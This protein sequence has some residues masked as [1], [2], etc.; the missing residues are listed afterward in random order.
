MHSND[1]SYPFCFSNGFEFSALA[2]IGTQTCL[3]YLLAYPTIHYQN[4]PNEQGPFCDDVPLIPL[5]VSKYLAVTL[6]T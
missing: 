1:Y 5:G 3:S 6:Q 4:D 2:G